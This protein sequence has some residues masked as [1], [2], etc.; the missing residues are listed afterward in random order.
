MNRNRRHIRYRQSVYRRHSIKTG[1]IVAA[2]VLVVLVLLFLILG[3][4]LFNKVQD[5]PEDTDKTANT[6]PAPDPYPFEDVRHVK[7]PL[8]SLDGNRSAIYQTLGNL[9]DEGHKAVSIPLT[10]SDGT[11]LYHSEQ[12]VD[13]DYAI[14]GTSTLSLSDLAEAA[15][16]DGVYLCGYFVLSATAEEDPL[17]RSVLLAESAAVLAEAFLAGVDDIVIVAPALPLEQQAELLRLCDTVRTFVPNAIIGLSLPEAEIAAPDAKR[18]DALAKSFDF[19][20]LDL[21]GYGDEEPVAFAEARMQSMLYYLLRYEMRVLIPSLTDEKV[22]NALIA[23]TE[24]ES[25]TN[26]MLVHPQV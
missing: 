23:V 5:E 19:L 15:K 9:V 26:W 12:A 22:Q 8:L 11:L 18:I 17:T 10:N 1:L 24:T 4:L 25:V 6:I 3:N 16:A 21:S 2:V 14:R 20:A 7:A 13:G